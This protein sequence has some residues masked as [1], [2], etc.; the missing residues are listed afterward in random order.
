MGR[1]QAPP[2]Q[3]NNLGTTNSYICSRKAILQMYTS[4]DICGRKFLSPLNVCTVAS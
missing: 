2:L 3:A 1:G 4:A